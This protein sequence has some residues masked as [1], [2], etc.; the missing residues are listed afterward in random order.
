MRQRCKHWSEQGLKHAIALLMAFMATLAAAQMPNELNS[1]LVEARLAVIADTGEGETAQTLRDWNGKELVV[2]NKEFITGRL[3]NWSLSDNNTR[4]IINVGIA[5]GSDLEAALALLEKLVC[6]HELVIEDPAPSV[7]MSE[8][9]DNALT[10]TA[11]YFVASID[12]LWLTKSEL[13]RTI[14]KEFNAAGIVI[15][16]PQRD[17]HLD[18][19]EPIR[20]A[21]DHGAAAQRETRL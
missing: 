2:P 19:A 4:I 5:Y 13:H 15:A 9:G 11:R 17:V 8:F 14:Y 16:F 20:I 7:I 6:S 21:I 18:S 10:L 12:H 1:T 3:L